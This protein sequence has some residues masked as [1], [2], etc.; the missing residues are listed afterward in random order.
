M[1]QLV[2]Y[3]TKCP[4]DFAVACGTYGYYTEGNY[5]PSYSGTISSFHGVIDRLCGLVYFY[6]S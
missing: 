5:D 2:E 4:I 6:M 3:G 1:N